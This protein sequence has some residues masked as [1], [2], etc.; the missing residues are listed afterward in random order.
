MLIGSL[1]P[2]DG[3][4][5]QRDIAT[6]LGSYPGMLS[7]IELTLS[8]PRMSTAKGLRNVGSGF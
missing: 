3:L 4:L 8:V 5:D 2:A 6:A 7:S 1:T